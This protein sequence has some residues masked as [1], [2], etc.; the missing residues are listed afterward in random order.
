VYIGGFSFNKFITFFHK[1]WEVVGDDVMNFFEEFHTHCKF[2]KSLNATF[3]ALIPKKRDA[4]NIRDFR[5][6]SLVGSMYKLLS[7][8]LANR[9]RLVMDSLISSSQNA[10]VGGRQTLDSVLIANECLD[11]R[12]K[13]FYPRDSL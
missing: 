12:L 13:K 9:I 8:V 5:P 4:L 3:I 6:I 10:F 2:E 1:C 7:K 11:S